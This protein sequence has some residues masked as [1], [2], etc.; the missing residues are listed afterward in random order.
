MNANSVVAASPMTEEGAKEAR[1]VPL[2]SQLLW[3]PH[4][5]ITMLVLIALYLVAIFQ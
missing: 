4:M 1:P 3:L 2:V 5:V